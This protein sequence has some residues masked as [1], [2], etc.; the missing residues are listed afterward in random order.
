MQNYP[1]WTADPI[2]KKVKG[3]N[4]K[5]RA[6]IEILLSKPGLRVDL[7]KARGLFNKIARH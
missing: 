4:I 6:W 2:S 7:A 3:V 5:N 1:D